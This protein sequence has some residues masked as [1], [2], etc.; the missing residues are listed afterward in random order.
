[1]LA[2]PWLASA[3]PRSTRGT[4]TVAKPPQR[5]AFIYFPNGVWEKSWVPQTTGTD[6]E[7]TPSL[8]PIADIRGDVTVVTK[9]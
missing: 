6:Y 3:L 8:Q 1:M 4:E 5:A 2:L 9:H 7:L